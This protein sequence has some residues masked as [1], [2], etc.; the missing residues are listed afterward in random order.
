MNKSA[1][2]SRA[3]VRTRVLMT[4]KIFSVNGA[5]EVR[6]RDISLSGAHLCVPGPLPVETDV[7]FKRGSIFAAGRIMWSNK[8]Q[9]GVKFYRELL[10]DQLDGTFHSV[11]EI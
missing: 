1:H 8:E 11:L 7:I 2:C 10:P 4:G 5:H 3:H 6:I 9:T